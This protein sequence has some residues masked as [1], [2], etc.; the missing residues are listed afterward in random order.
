MLVR[1]ARRRVDGGEAGK[2]TWH[3]WARENIKLSPSRLHELQC[4]AGAD[5]PAEE[6]G[7]IR[8]LTRERVK[9]H[10]ASK[11]IEARGLEDERRQLIAWAKTAPLEDV[12]R[13]LA[14]VNGTPERQQAA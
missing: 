13:V 10:R 4:I 12:S 8:Q 2:N 11:A 1:E 9:N 6:L 7:R 5:D 3:E 14:A